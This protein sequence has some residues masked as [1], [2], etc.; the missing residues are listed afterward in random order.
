MWVRSCTARLPSIVYFAYLD[1][2]H[3][4]V[5]VCATSLSQS[6]AK[7]EVGPRSGKPNFQDTAFC[8]MGA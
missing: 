8:S 7:K 5:D 3:L 2:M 1:C 6:C 4:F